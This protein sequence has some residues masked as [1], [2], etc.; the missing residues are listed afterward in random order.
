LQNVPEE[1]LTKNQRR[2]QARELARKERERAQ[3][4]DRL[5]KILVPVVVVVV[6]LVAGGIVAAVVINQPKPAPIAANGPKNM[7]GDG[8]VLTGQGGKIVATRTP[9]LKKGQSPSPIPT[10]TASGAPIHIT[11]YVDWACPVCKAFEEANSTYIS[12]L[13]KSGQAV[14]QVMP[15]AIVDRSYQSSRYASRANNAAACVANYDPDSFLTVQK[16][17]YDDQPAEG[18]TGLS[19]GQI[20]DLVKKAGL[21]DDKVTSCINGESFKNFVL[22]ATQRAT[23]DPTL[24][25]P[26]AQSFGTPTVV[27]NGQLYGAQDYSSTTEFPAFVKSVS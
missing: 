1:R 10:D 22:A 15:V 8:I 25:A 4:R 2:E 19:N 21:N 26:G 13:V 5:M 20:V 14:L 11:T 16:Q 9:A 12:G 24:V 17:F 7:I 18:S 23:S 3:R 27:V 6:L